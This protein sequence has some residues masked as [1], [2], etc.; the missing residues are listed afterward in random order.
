MNCDLSASSSFIIEVQR[1]L[2]CVEIGHDI[3]AGEDL[4]TKTPDS[5]CKQ[6]SH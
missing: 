4:L 5:V 6:L 2:E 1:M 3:S